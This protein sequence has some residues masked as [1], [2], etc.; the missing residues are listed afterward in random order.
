MSIGAD[1]HIS[2]AGARERSLDL[3]KGLVKPMMQRAKA[4][5][6]LLETK[7]TAVDPLQWLDRIDDIENRD[8]RRR[9]LKGKTTA[10][11]PPRAHKSALN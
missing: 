10:L 5:P 6:M 9:T 3:E 11:T 7:R 8:F 1:H 4:V 2:D